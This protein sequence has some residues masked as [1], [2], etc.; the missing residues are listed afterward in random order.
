MNDI[1]KN[2]EEYNPNKKRKTLIFFD[3]MITDM[4]NNKKFHPGGNLII[5]QKTKHFSLFL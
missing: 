4:L 2:C 3:Y 1:Y 5:Y